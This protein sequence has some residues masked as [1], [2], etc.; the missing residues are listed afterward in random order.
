MTKNE[1]LKDFT[2]NIRA[3]QKY[4]RNIA[5]EQDADDL[6]QECAL[7]LLELPEE[8]LL[9]YYNPDQGLKPIF[10][11][12]LCNQY[13]SK[14]SKFHKEYRKQQI[15]L[16]TKGADIVYNDQ[17]TELEP[18]EVDY[19]EMIKARDQVYALNGE[20]F[21]SALEEMI[22]NLYVE[23]GSLRKTLAAIDPDEVAKHSAGKKTEELFDLKTVHTIVKKF[24]KTIKIYFKIND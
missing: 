9:S 17:A 22:F 18:F 11:R 24:R 1:I 12:I 21:P 14:T 8:K 15:F 10:I 7:M 23:T 16:Q 13:K 20:M 6:F 5:G 4:A 19:N 2:D 3:F